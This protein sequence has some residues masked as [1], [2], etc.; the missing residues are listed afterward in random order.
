MA[1]NNHLGATVQTIKGP[2]DY[3]MTT[4]SPDMLRT[5]D[6]HLDN[7]PIDMARN[8]HNPDAPCSCVDCMAGAPGILSD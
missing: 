1:R 3:D 6:G 4:A 2:R 8:V 7:Y 5:V